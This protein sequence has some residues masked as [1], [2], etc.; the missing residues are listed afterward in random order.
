MEKNIKILK[1]VWK[2]V[3]NEDVEVNKESFITD[4]DALTVHDYSLHKSSIEVN[5]VSILGEK[6]ETVNG[7]ILDVTTMDY[8]SYWEPPDSNTIELGSHEQFVDAVISM[9]T[10]EAKNRADIEVEN[11]TMEEMYKEQKEIPYE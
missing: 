3:F 4:N 9:I 2:A 10:I 1:S 5:R 7:W 8:G 11:N 6:T